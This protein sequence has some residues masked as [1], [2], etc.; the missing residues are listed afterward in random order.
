MK[1]SIN[2]IAE[3]LE[4]ER[5]PTEKLLLP[6]ASFLLL[7]AILMASAW[8][9]LNA[10]TMDRQFKQLVV[11]RDALTTEVTRL[12]RDIMNFQGQET[13]E[14]QEAGKKLTTVKSL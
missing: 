11:Q 10:R 5:F 8:E 12:T 9:I 6:A 1:T 7:L 4:R 3:I 2:L 14:Q 13:T